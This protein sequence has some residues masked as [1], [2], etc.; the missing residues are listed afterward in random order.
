MEWIKLGFSI[1]FRIPEFRSSSV[2]EEKEEEEEE[3]EEEKWVPFRQFRMMA[4]DSLEN[5]LEKR[6]D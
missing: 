2:E 6:W 1:Q 5:D 4:A 3:E